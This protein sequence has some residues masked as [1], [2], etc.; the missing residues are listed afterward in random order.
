MKITSKPRRKTTKRKAKF[1]FS[2][3][4]AGVRLEGKLD[5]TA[6]K[7]C[8]P[9]YS[10]KIKRGKHIL[11]VRGIDLGNNTGGATTYRWT[12]K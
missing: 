3:S 6:Y 7:P 5:R 8:G 12:V 1:R 9:S 4:E 11:R 10:K 2:A